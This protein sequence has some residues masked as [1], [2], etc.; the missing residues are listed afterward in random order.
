ML[1]EDTSPWREEKG[2]GGRTRYLNET[3]G[4]T[5][6]GVR[7]TR[8]HQD[9][10]REVQYRTFLS[11]SLSIHTAE[12]VDGAPVLPSIRPNVRPPS[13]PS[14]TTIG[15]AIHPM[16]RE[17]DPLRLDFLSN[18]RRLP[19]CKVEQKSPLQT[20]RTVVDYISVVVWS[21]PVISS[22]MLG[23]V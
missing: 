6:Y 17:N 18:S 3:V 20:R 13:P 2:P 4:K 5:S 22:E 21:G 9:R 10:E 1:E 7:I 8:S 12:P 11:Q 15:G 16:A 23:S 19:P 14:R